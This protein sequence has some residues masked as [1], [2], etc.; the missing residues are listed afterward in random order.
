MSL[1]EI[2]ELE[3]RAF[4]AWPALETRANFGW[5]QRFAGGYTKRAN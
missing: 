1:M 4:Q 2:R 3:Q 5:V